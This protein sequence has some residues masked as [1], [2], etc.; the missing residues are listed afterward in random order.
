MKK[1]LWQIAFVALLAVSV[2]AVTASTGGVTPAATSSPH[3]LGL[4]DYGTD[5]DLDYCY[6]Y[7]APFGNWVQ[8]DPW[9]YVWCPR[10]MGYRWR[11]YTQG[12]WIWT[13][14][15]W[16]WLSDFEWGWIPFHYGR[17]GWDDDLGWFWVPGTTWGPAWVTWRSGD[18]Y[19][20]WAPFP[21]GMEFR[22]GMDFASFGMELPGRFWVFI[23]ASH[24]LDRD[25]YS[26]V[27][28]FERNIT[29]MNYTT[30]HNNFVFRGTRFI[31]EGLGVDTIRRLTRRE[32]LQ[33]RL[34]DSRQPGAAR[35]VGNDV[36]LYRPSFT[37]RPGNQPK[38]FLNREEAKREVAP[39][40]IYESR[41]QPPTRTAE[42][43]VRQRQGAERKLMKD[44][45]SQ[46]LKALDKRQSEEQKKAQA[47]AERSRIQQNYQNGK[48]E[49][50]K[51][52]QT[53]KQQ[54]GD[55]HKAD[56]EQARRADQ[57]RRQAPPV[58]KKK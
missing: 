36:Q 27:L 55:R 49:M 24:F 52:H 15:G 31:N 9:G 18:I 6:N 13:D 26:C 19:T 21:P 46:D 3:A 25:L 40:R 23:G 11:P 14:F 4:Q 41:E 51:Q 1:T 38:V 20:G 48:S 56:A 34:Q 58:K 10:H 17:W 47:T 42:T 53:E 22:A 44:S 7:L 12:H 57:S 8:L 5:L 28:P 43:A 37:G 29:L 16:T 32:V 45:Q 30:I 54:M 2:P 33:Y 50:S 35:I 39:A